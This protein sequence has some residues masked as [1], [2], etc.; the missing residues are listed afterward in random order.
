MHTMHSGDKAAASEQ[1]FSDSRHKYMELVV[2][3]RVCLILKR[4]R[5]T[6]LYRISFS[7]N[8]YKGTQLVKSNPCHL[9]DL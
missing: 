4:K 6:L 5:D 3:K 9:L 7:F 1:G 2:M 8:L